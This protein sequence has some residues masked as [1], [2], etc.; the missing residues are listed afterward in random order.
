MCT[1]SIQR[2]RGVSRH[3]KTWQLTT[4]IALAKEVV[5]AEGKGSDRSKANSKRRTPPRDHES[6]QQSADVQYR[7]RYESLSVHAAQLHAC[8]HLPSYPR[9]PSSLLLSAPHPPSPQQI[10][11]SAPRYASG[12]PWVG[13]DRWVA[14]RLCSNV[15]WIQH[16]GV[17]CTAGC[18]TATRT[19]NTHTT[20]MCARPP[21]V[22][23]PRGVNIETCLGRQASGWGRSVEDGE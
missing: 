12:A 17:V 21:N 6:W 14:A 3:R 5:P 16:P 23:V 22:N 8:M 13:V 7:R 11:F 2:V 10:R 9:R 18:T 1:T 15:C 20:N 19:R 4:S